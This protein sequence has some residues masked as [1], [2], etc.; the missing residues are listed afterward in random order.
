MRGVVAFLATDP[1]RIRKAPMCKCKH[2]EVYFCNYVP[3]KR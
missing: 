2:A 3:T 1:A